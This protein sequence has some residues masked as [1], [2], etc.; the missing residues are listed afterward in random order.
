MHR[1]FLSNLTF[2]LFVNLLVKPLWI[3]GIDR[4]VQN[5][6]GS[7]TYGV[8]FAILNLSFIYYM[9]LDLGLSNFNN[10]AVA[11]QGSRLSRLMPDVL[12]LKLV[13]GAAYFLVT[14]L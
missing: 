5:T 9:L 3:F 8:Y 14:Y 13:F 6:V 7:E 2:L 10:R 12:M 1:K 4:T 11:R